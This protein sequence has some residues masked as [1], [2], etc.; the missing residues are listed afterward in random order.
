MPFILAIV[1]F[2]VMVLF[3]KHIKWWL[4]WI[5]FVYYIVL[6]SIFNNGRQKLEEKYQSQPIE[7]LWDKNSDYVDHFVPLFNIPL[8]LILIICYY[9]WFK[10]AK[11]KKTKI[12]LGISIF[13][14]AILYLWFCLM[15]VM[16]GYQP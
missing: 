14:V 10:H 9:L 5:P 8:L 7:T 16:F 1:V 12:R 13:P 6:S 15:I 3:H 11:E 2:G 4:K